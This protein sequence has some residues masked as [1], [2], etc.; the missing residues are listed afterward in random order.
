MDLKSKNEEKY[1]TI[2]EGRETI[3]D[4]ATVIEEIYKNATLKCLMNQTLLVTR[5]LTL[6][7]TKNSQHR[8]PFLIINF[9]LLVQIKHK[10]KK[11]K[12]THRRCISTEMGSDDESASSLAHPYVQTDTEQPLHSSIFFLPLRDTT[13]QF[14]ITS[15]ST[16][17]A[18]SPSSSGRLHGKH[19]SVRRRGNT[20]PTRPLSGKVIHSRSSPKGDMLIRES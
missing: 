20:T 13:F 3:Y 14:Q 6:K 10:K 19:F 15:T 17:R 9:E 8:L 11:Q 5:F 1:P 12:M 16:L 7:E 18:R 2:S 4:V